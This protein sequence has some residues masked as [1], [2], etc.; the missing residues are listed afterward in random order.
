MHYKVCYRILEIAM[1]E[2][3]GAIPLSCA[4]SSKCLLRPGL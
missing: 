4:D 3:D 2:E 1:S